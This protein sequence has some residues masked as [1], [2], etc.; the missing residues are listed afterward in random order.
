MKT[1]TISKDCNTN[2]LPVASN[3][4][5]GYYVS[6]INE[7]CYVENCETYFKIFTKRNTI[8]TMPTSSFNQAGGYTEVEKHLHELNPELETH[9]L[10]NDKTKAI[11]F[12]VLD[13]MAFVRYR[14]ELF[15][16]ESKVIVD[17]ATKSGVRKSCCQ[18]VRVYVN[19]LGTYYN[20][21]L[22]LTSDGEVVKLPLPLGEGYKKKGD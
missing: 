1:E 7:F 6:P 11:F 15:F 22:T 20:V 14:E 16:K 4:K 10:L 2:N 17:E 9:V 5:T 21:Y 8:I 12:S 3:R 19:S 18:K 13:A